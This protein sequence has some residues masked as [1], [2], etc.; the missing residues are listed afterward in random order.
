MGATAR[1]IKNFPEPLSQIGYFKGVSSDILIRLGTNSEIRQLMKGDLLVSAGCVKDW[2]VYLV[3]EGQIHLTSPTFESNRSLRFV[4]PGMTF[5][6]SALLMQTP[7]PYQAV[8]SR[9]SQILVINGHS[10]LTEIESAPEMCGIVLKQL[11]L[12]ML[13]TMHM[14]VASAG[15]TDLSR[16]AGYFMDFR[17]ASKDESFSFILPARKMDI[18][19]NLGMSNASF[20]RALQRLRQAGFIDVRGASVHVLKA[21]QLNELASDLANQSKFRPPLKPCPYH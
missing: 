16:V 18:A 8:A 12:R 13:N 14:L 15:R 3:L 21:T 2:N 17:P 19:A 1:I 11:A 6:E 9:K 10:W 20:S 7:P 5:G 4:D